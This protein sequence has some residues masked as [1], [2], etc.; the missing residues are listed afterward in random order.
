MSKPSATISSANS[1]AQTKVLVRT[2]VIVRPSSQSDLTAKDFGQSDESFKVEITTQDTS[3][4]EIA[5]LVKDY[6]RKLEL[7]IGNGPVDLILSAFG[8][9]G[10]GKGRTLLGY[11]GDTGVAH[12]VF[13]EFG[14]E[15]AVLEL[16][17]SS[18]AQKQTQIKCLVRNRYLAME[19]KSLS[20]TLKQACLCSVKALNKAAECR[21]TTQKE[22][23]HSSRSILV[24]TRG[25]TS[26]RPGQ[27]ITVIDPPGQETTKGASAETSKASNGPGGATINQAS[28]DL[29]AFLKRIRQGNFAFKGNQ[30][31]VFSPIA[32]LH[33]HGNPLLL[34]IIATLYGSENAVEK[35]RLRDRDV[36]GFVQELAGINALK[37][38]LWHLS[39]PNIGNLDF[40]LGKPPR[41]P[42]VRLLSFNAQGK[43]PPFRHAPIHT[44]RQLI[45]HANATSVKR[46]H[47][48]ASSHFIWHRDGHLDPDIKEAHPA[49]ST[50]SQ[51][52]R[53]VIVLIFDRQDTQAVN[54]CEASVKDG[55]RLSISLTP[56]SGR[57]TVVVGDL[58]GGQPELAQVEPPRV[59]NRYRR[60]GYLLHG[61]LTSKNL[62]ITKHARSPGIYPT[63]R[64]RQSEATGDRR[65]SEQSPHELERYMASVPVHQIPAEILL[66]VF[67]HVLGVTVAAVRETDDVYDRRLSVLCKVCTHWH[68]ILKSSPYIPT[69]I[70]PY[71][72]MDRLLEIVQQPSECNLEVTYDLSGSDEWEA[73][74]GS[75][76]QFF[77]IIAPS[78]D[79]WRSLVFRFTHDMVDN[80]VKRVL[81]RACPRLERLL[82]NNETPDLDVSD[83]ELFCGS[84][85]KLKDV[86]MLGI[87]CR[88]SQP[89][90]KGLKCLHLGCIDFGS[91]GEIEEML[92]GSPGLQELR[93]VD[94]SVRCSMPSDHPRC[95]NRVSLFN[96]RSLTASFHK[97]ASDSTTQLN[98][99]LTLVSAPSSCALFIPYTRLSDYEDPTACF[100]Q[101]LFGRQPRNAFET[102]DGLE[103]ELQSERF[104]LDSLS[105]GLLSGS[106]RVTGGG[107]T[108]VSPSDATSIL[109]CV[110]KPCRLS[111]APA[112]TTKLNVWLSCRMTQ[113]LQDADF[114]SQLDK[115]P[116]ITHLELTQVAEL[117][118]STSHLEGTLS[119]ILLSA[120]HLTFR[121]VRSGVI[122]MI[123]RKALGGPSDPPSNEV[124]GGT[125]NTI[126]IYVELEEQRKAEMLVKTLRK[127]R[128]IGTVKLYVT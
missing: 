14:R 95:P 110:Q 24:M 106:S 46:G 102:I 124:A 73:T 78:A 84:T 120:R 119:S 49:A 82:L 86:R 109:A 104:K 71:V 47:C 32:D 56:V 100:E 37:G 128:R 105:F 58:K 30:I 50:V 65:S 44:H 62:N 99:L 125:L 61:K 117:P 6:A 36:A 28:M 122:A 111:S 115:L 38:S 1:K 8:G 101:W 92:K 96:L 87:T 23:Q 33:Q 59:G 57:S 108:F 53:Q 2:L 113:L 18:P 83:I 85:T 91:A 112:L 40:H 66:C 116:P 67:E 4:K 64:Y 13:Q 22:H 10:S 60:T 21:K 31:S 41:P 27:R 118:L 103:L 75:P 89:V 72:E 9:T 17:L 98:Q 48:S 63:R 68:T 69:R 43:P 74:G 11:N 107:M 35:H 12:Q 127:D 34:C 25:P 93:I 20:A 45:R 26:D 3:N 77:D 16:E 5:E 29:K 42:S 80:S 70:S 52:A 79:R 76:G 51:A 121:N 39:P 123:A 19:Q 90:F 97:S 94:C 55:Q 7:E 81:G 15:I 126:R 88:W 54:I 114:R